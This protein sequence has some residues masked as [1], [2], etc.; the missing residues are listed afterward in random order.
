MS[1]YVMQH[2]FVRWFVLTWCVHLIA[3]IAAIQALAYIFAL[4]DDIDKWLSANRIV[5]AF[6]LVVHFIAYLMARVISMDRDRLDE[7]ASTDLSDEIEN[8]H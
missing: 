4:S 2:W 6:L 5:V 3:Q 7:I 8:D 1:R